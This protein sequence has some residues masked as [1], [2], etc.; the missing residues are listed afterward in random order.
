[1][2]ALKT[3]SIV[4]TI[5]ATVL[6]I[7]QTLK[8]C[9]APGGAPAMVQATSL[10][11]APP[12]PVAPP[13]TEEE[14]LWALSQQEN[15]ISV[16]EDFLTRY[17]ESMFAAVARSKVEGLKEAE[18]REVC[19]SYAATLPPPPRPSTFG[20]ALLAGIVGCGV[21][22]ATSRDGC[23]AG[24]KGGIAGAANTEEAAAKEAADLAQQKIVRDTEQCV[25][26]GGPPGYL[27]LSATPVSVSTQ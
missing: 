26:A 4:V 11:E 6:G 25:L 24:A 18:I 5:I 2:D 8:S 23:G 12:A 7:F 10:P 17:P 9:S 3:T 13:P 27:T 1:M 20:R 21:G 15:T 19:S 16:Y 14:K 22:A